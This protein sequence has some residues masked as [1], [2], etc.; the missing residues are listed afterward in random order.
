M[1]CVVLTLLGFIFRGIYLLK[2][3]Q[4]PSA[5]WIKISPHIVDTVL[6]LTGIGLALIIVPGRDLGS[7][8]WLYIKLSAVVLY[9]VLGIFA[10][11]KYYSAAVNGILVLL[12]L[13]A[14]GFVVFMA[15]NRPYVHLT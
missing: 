7:V 13:G 1:A 14:F 6:L 4:K 15:L 10:L 11:R 8:A 5:R 9:I 12:A 2:N 3:K